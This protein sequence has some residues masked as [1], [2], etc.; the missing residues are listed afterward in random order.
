MSS[1]QYTQTVLSIHDQTE[2][3]FTK[4]HKLFLTLLIRTSVA[5]TVHNLEK[6]MKVILFIIFLNRNGVYNTGNDLKGQGKKSKRKNRIPR[7]IS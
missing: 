2:N 1:A 6:M 7:K 5:N 4:N 3:L